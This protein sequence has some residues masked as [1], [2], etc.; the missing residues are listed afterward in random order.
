VELAA[1]REVDAE[2]EAL[3]ILVARVQFLVLGN[4]DGLSS[5]AA[6]MSTVAKLLKGRIN[7]AAAN[8]VC[9]GFC[10]L[11]VATVLHFLESETELA[12]LRFGHSANLTLDEADAL[13]I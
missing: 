9:C 6:S 5:L 12:V 8:G 2:L 7:V 11:L 4:T 3:W 13:W 10:S 1:R